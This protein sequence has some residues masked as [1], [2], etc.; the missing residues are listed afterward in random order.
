MA[1]FHNSG[2]ATAT[3]SSPAS[4]D[5][6]YDDLR[7]YVGAPAPCRRP[8]YV[9]ASWRDGVFDSGVG[10]RQADGGRPTFLRRRPTGGDDISA[11]GRRAEVRGTV[12][13]S[14]DV[15]LSRL[16]HHTMIRTRHLTVA[17]GVQ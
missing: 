7:L 10:P 14:S 16:V 4:P 9:P 6:C 15:V 3:V 11:T 1:V 2:T 13:E 8:P 5:G 17:V 12:L